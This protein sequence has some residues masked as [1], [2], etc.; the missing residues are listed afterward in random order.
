[1]SIA[2]EISRL[3]TAKGNIKTAIESKG[4]TVS[5]ATTLDGYAALINSINAG[6]EYEEGTYTPESDIARPTINFNNTHTEPPI[7]VAMYDATDDYDTTTT[8]NWGFLYFDFYKAWGIGYPYNSSS[9]RYEI[10]TYTYRGTSTSSISCTSTQI[11]ANSD[12]ATTS[13]NSAKYFVTN[14]NFKPY[15]NST[16]RYWKA[17][18]THKWI[19][20]WK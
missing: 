13:S 11:S 2:S 6:L 19:A 5:S 1:M 4:V 15:S 7:F 10:V 9:K 12:S 17:G 18:R 20:I 8:K 3:Q 14:T 16:S